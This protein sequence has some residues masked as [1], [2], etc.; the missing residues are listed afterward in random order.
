MKGGSI[1]IFFGLFWSG[2]TLLFD[3]FMILPAV[4]Q[5]AAERF[6]TTQGTVLSSEVTHHDDSD[7][8]THGVR[9]TY[10]YTVAG[11][12]FTGDRFRYGKFSSS[13]SAWARQAVHEHT[14]GSTTKV[15]YDPNNPTESVL[16][17]G[18][19]GCDLF[20]LMFMTP[21]NA[22]M[23]VFWA[24]GWSLLRRRW[25]NP[26]AG[27][28]KLRTEL[29]RTRARLSEYSP[30]TAGIAT[31][32]LLAFVGMFVV[33]FGFGGFHPSL[34]VVSVAWGVIL[35]GGI[36]AAGWHWKNILAGKY[37]LVIDDLNGTIHLP[38]TCGRKVICRLPRAEIY[39][40]FVETVA[41]T[42]NEGSTSYTYVLTLR[43]TGPDGP[44]EKLATWHSEER[45]R[46]FVVWLN[47]RLAATRTPQPPRPIQLRRE[48]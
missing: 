32:A 6:A 5:V 13:D 30:L 22:V 15:Y 40:S 46:G 37:D 44:T 38:R 8:T 25:H 20:M 9:I 48:E 47:D 27:G 14:V 17:P 24:A 43:L 16:R 28:I 4:R 23:L 26:V 42:D 33:A 35:A 1:L 34:R 31:I 11:R 2:M 36:T 39:S 7:G 41:K 12:E 18:L 29:R 3:G 10:S 45:A 19:A 21:F